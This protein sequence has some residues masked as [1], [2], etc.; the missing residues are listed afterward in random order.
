MS[1]LTP[2]ERAK[3]VRALREDAQM[4]PANAPGREEAKHLRELADK[5]E[6]EPSSERPT[7][8][9]DW[10]DEDE[11]LGGWVEIDR[12]AWR[13]IVRLAGGVGNLSVF[14]TLTDL[15]GAYGAPQ[16]YTAWGPA[17]GVNPLI[18]VRDYKASDGS[19]E[20][21]VFRRFVRFDALPAS[22][23]TL[24]E[25]DEAREAL[26]D[27]LDALDK[28][29]LAGVIADMETAYR[30]QTGGRMVL[31]GVERTHALVPNE[32]LKKAAWFA[33]CR[34][35]SPVGLDASSDAKIWEERLL[36]TA[37]GERVDWPG[38]A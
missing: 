7:P 33:R 16:I 1:A 25:R 8:C 19:T 11:P 21:S 26:R 27:L 34:A 17:G 4:V 14:S 28:V 20:R 36:A 12:N 18:D 15:E 5:L 23:D 37:R 9:W 38:V 10:L 35:K 31:E 13:S 22:T 3:I 2:D 6:A 30:A 24:R 32:V 29:R